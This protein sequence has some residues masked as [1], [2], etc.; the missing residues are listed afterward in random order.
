MKKISLILVI[1]LLVTILCGCS[2]YKYDFQLTQEE[3]I[4]KFPVLEKEGEGDVYLWLQELWDEYYYSI[5]GLNG[6]TEW[7]KDERARLNE[8]FK[9]IKNSAGKEGKKIY[10]ENDAVIQKLIRFIDNYNSPFIN[11]NSRTLLG[12]SA[13]EKYGI[14][15]ENATKVGDF[16]FVIYETDIR[17]AAIIFHEAGYAIGVINISKEPLKKEDFEKLT[18][19]MNVSEVEEVDPSTIVFSRGEDVSSEFLLSY[20]YLDNG[21]VITINYEYN[22]KDELVIKEINLDDRSMAEG[23]FASGPDIIYHIRNS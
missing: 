5:S 17:K 4:E 16:Y 7:A 21:D 2:K 18:V 22:D 6:N 10:S 15:F 11:Y 8:E 13:F 12:V 14:V 23:I 3:V 1:I 19:G 9:K 20:H